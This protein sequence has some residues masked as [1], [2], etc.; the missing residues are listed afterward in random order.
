V[1]GQTSSPM[2]EKNSLAVSWGQGATIIKKDA[3]ESTGYNF[4]DT[5]GQAI[6]AVVLT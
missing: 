5:Q 3:K 6:C 1:T 4:R 2:S